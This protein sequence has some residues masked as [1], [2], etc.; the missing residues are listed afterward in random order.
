MELSLFNSSNEVSNVVN[1]DD[2]KNS[3]TGK[4]DQC[5][6]DA[7]TGNDQFVNAESRMNGDSGESVINTKNSTMGEE[8]GSTVVTDRASEVAKNPIPCRL[9]L[10][11]QN[12]FQPADITKSVTLSTDQD[13]TPYTPATP[14]KGLSPAF[15]NSDA[16]TIST[17]ATPAGG[18]TT[19]VDG[20]NAGGDAEYYEQETRLVSSMTDRLLDDAYRIRIKK[21]VKTSVQ[22]KVYNFLERPTGWKCFI[23]H[24]T[25]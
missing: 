5:T 15:W 4:A 21:P 8:K 23:Y 14:S 13:A 6:A 10:P 20:G 24:F 12:V 18:R 17:K 3:E 19:S 1:S 16:P 9:T 2:I 7:T 22:V 25:V 11:N